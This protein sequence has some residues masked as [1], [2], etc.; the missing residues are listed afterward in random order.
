MKLWRHDFGTSI[1]IAIEDE[2]KTDRQSVEYKYFSFVN[3]G[4][5]S[6]QPCW[7]TDWMLYFWTNPEALHKALIEANLFKLLNIDC[8]RSKGKKGGLMPEAVKSAQTELDSIAYLAFLGEGRSFNH[9]Q[10]KMGY[11]EYS[12]PNIN[13]L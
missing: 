11:L 5:T 8:G 6:G 10:Y 1:A 9:H 4:A 3:H 12:T 13:Y 7:M 2:T